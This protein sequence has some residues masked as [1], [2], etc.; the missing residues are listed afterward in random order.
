MPSPRSK[1]EVGPTGARHY[2][3]FMNVLSLGYYPRLIR[4]VVDKMNIQRG[5]SILDL[6]SGT[7]RNDCFIAQ[8]IGTNGSILG[9]D[10]SKQML[11]LSRRRCQAYPNVEFREQRIEMSLAY[12]DEFDKVFIS[13]VWHG[14]EDAQKVGIINNAYQALK[15]GEA[16]YILDCNEFDLEKLWFPLRWAFIRW[17]CQLALEFLKLD[18]KKMLSSQGFTSFEEEL[19]PK[20][21]P[22][23][24]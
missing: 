1:V 7:G 9:L 11:R 8:K 2:D 19:F 15:P 16:F 5:Q 10:I 6:G 12:Q 21:T 18:L 22:T 17:E 13:F 23:P 24:A 4:K 3:L 14:F 20:R